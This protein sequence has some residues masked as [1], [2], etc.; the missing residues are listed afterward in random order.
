MERTVLITGAAGGLGQVVTQHFIKHEWEVIATALTREEHE[1]L[2]S[3][4]HCR[5]VECDVT[6]YDHV[7]KLK[8]ELPPSLA[9]VVHLVGGIR[10]G[11]PI[12]ETAVEDFHWMWRLNTLSTYLVL[13]ATIPILKRNA[14][15]FVAIGAR[16][17]LHPETNKALYGAAKSAVVHLILAAAEEGRATG[18]RAN[19]IVPSVLRTQANL[20]WA[21]D[22]E[23]QLWVD[24]AHVA[25]VILF[26]CSEEGR[27]LTGCVLPMYGK[28]PG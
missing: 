11:K 24:P 22:G 20:E 18:M 27:A 14:G 21:R 13:H 10:A 23:E 25:E 5:T 4:D 8:G 9:A 12:E 19:V 15:A 26:L 17:V 1:W 2:A 6:N 3:L 16:T 28:L 7:A